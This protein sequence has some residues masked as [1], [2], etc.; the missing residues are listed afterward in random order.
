MNSLLKYYWV[1]GL[2]GVGGL[3]FAAFLEF[4]PL[5][6][7]LESTRQG[8]LSRQIVLADSLILLDRKIGEAQRPYLGEMAILSVESL[9][10]TQERLWQERKSFFNKQALPQAELRQNVSAPSW[11]LHKSFIYPLALCS[12]GLVVFSLILFLRKNKKVPP[13]FNSSFKDLPLKTN[14]TPRF[15]EAGQTESFEQVLKKLAQVS[16]QI[17]PLSPQSSRAEEKTVEPKGTEKQITLATQSSSV[18]ETE[19]RKPL[20][21]FGR[22]PQVSIAFP[23]SGRGSDRDQVVRLHLKGLSSRLIARDLR[24]SLHEVQLI[25]KTSVDSPAES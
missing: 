18:L 1:F 6:G 2:T 11:A 21:S 9:Q 16:Q 8:A 10:V 13:S 24:M 23:P 22:S 5:W 20:E 25:I 3:V 15:Q 17:T 4:Y 12:L 7:S 14:P 19:K